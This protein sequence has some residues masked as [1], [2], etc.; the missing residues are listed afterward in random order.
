MTEPRLPPRVRAKRYRERARE[1]RVRSANA[2]GEAHGVFLSLAGQ[3][4]QLA[5]EAEAEAE[6]EGG[7][8]N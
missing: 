5:L 3:W 2:K 1:A 8:G 6:A 7:S 4:D